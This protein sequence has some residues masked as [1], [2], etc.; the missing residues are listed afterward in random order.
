MLSYCPTNGL[1]IT[2]PEFE[3]RAGL[4]HCAENGG[5]GGI[6]IPFVCPGTPVDCRWHV[7]CFQHAFS[8]WRN[9]QVLCGYEKPPN[10]PE[11]VARIVAKSRV[12]W[13]SYPFE[14]RLPRFTQISLDK[15]PVLLFSCRT[16][17]ER[18]IRAAAKVGG[19]QMLRAYAV[20]RAHLTAWTNSLHQS[21]GLFFWPACKA[22]GKLFL[23]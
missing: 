21:Y 19:A 23:I 1:T 2:N 8:I 9:P 17:R 7:S 4:A 12:A 13:L 6:F 3:I 20:I 5:G 11:L 22:A 18:L 16:K 10:P 15:L 14:A